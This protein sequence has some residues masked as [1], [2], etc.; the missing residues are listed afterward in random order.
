MRCVERCVG[1][2]KLEPIQDPA[3]LKLTAEP[4]GQLTTEWPAAA[5]APVR[6]AEPPAET[7]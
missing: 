1:E 6:R 4:I 3:I 2:A 7:P 5:M